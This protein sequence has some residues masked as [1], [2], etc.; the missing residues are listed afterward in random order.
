MRGT[1]ITVTIRPNGARTEV[2][3]LPYAAGGSNYE[4]LGEAFG[5]T[6]RGQ[7]EYSSGVFSVSRSHTQAVVEF[8]ANRFGC[9]HVV[10][11]GGVDKCVSACWTANPDTAITCECSCAGS[12]HGSLR[13][14]GPVVADA[15]AAGELSVAAAPPREY[16]VF[17]PS[18]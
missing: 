15:G 1:G 3:G 13:P 4:L 12:N 10:Q 14:I 16:D 17:G 5:A 9:I 8:L 7:V 18:K 6:R 11:Y 2:R